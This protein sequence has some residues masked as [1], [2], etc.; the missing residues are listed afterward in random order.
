MI[1]KTKK[2]HFDIS[3]KEIKRER[4]R[5]REREIEKNLHNFPLNKSKRTF[6][7][8]LSMRRRYRCVRRLRIIINWLYFL[9]RWKTTTKQQ[10]ITTAT[11]ATTA[12]ATAAAAATYHFPSFYFHPPFPYF[13]PFTTTI[14][15]ENFKLYYRYWREANQRWNLNNLLSNGN[16]HDDNNN[17]SSSNNESPVAIFS[18]SFS[19]ISIS[20]VGGSGGGPRATAAGAPPSPR[21]AGLFLFLARPSRRPASLARINKPC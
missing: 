5:E 10:K 7:Q 17:S 4:E 21:A 8:L 13:L 12:T 9:T 3:S 1:I 20:W 18:P 15:S 6:Q 14:S 19:F 11:A 2:R 16:D